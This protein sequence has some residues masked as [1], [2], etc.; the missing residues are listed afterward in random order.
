MGLTASTENK[1]ERE[2]FRRFDRVLP[3]SILFDYRS[4]LWWGGERETEGTCER[5]KKKEKSKAILRSFDP[6][7]D[8]I[9]LIEA[10][11]LLL[12][13]RRFSRSNEQD[14]KGQNHERPVT[15]LL[16]LT[17]KR[18]NNVVATVNND[19]ESWGEKERE[20]E[21]QREKRNARYREARP[22]KSTPSRSYI[23]QTRRNIFLYFAWHIITDVTIYTRT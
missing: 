18:W 7:I 11:A 17:R 22:D 23:D 14:S 9:K 13:S 16:S 1:Y 2:Y 15:R 19:R 8:S 4:F 5:D 21:R 10:V 20:R 3:H 6:S 12:Y